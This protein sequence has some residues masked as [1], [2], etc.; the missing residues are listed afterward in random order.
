MKPKGSFLLNDA[1]FVI[2]VI[3]YSK[4]AD[5]LQRYVVAF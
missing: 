2:F 1:F 3:L 4:L 5:P